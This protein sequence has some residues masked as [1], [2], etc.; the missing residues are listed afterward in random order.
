VRAAL[1]GVD[2]E[3]IVVDD[4]SPDGTAQNVRALGRHDPRI[5]VIR[6]LGRRGLASACIEGMLAS[7]AA[8][9]AV[10]DADLSHDPC[11]LREMV[12]ILRSGRV[13]LVVASRE[14]AFSC[15]G[16]GAEPRTTARRWAA[17]AARLIGPVPLSDPLSGYFAL[18]REVIDRVAPRLAG[19]GHKLLLDILL[20]EPGLQICELAQPFG[21]RVR[22]EGKFSA[23]VIWD[24]GAMLAHHAGGAVPSRLLTYLPVAALALIAHAGTV[25]L[26]HELYGL[27]FGQAQLAAAVVLCIATY[28]FH[29]WLSYSRSGPWR[30]Y[31]AL[32]PFMASRAIGLL[33]ADL[34]ARAVAG[35]GIDAGV[36]ALA[37][38]ATLIWWNYD[39]V[40]RYGGFSR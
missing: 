27:G 18:R 30:W 13:D 24:Y 28:G 9:L 7:S 20:A 25:W 22:G 38:A 34:V 26:F 8:N 12:G 14:L 17:R 11:L 2:W 40:Q 6:R 5:R 4:D 3:L 23:R 19:A 29:E 31:L 1:N 21:M 37:G 39:A 16:E 15:P 35:S 10:M 36:A 33:A 32:V